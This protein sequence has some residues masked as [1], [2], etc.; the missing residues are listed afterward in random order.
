MKRTT[1]KDYIIDT[2]NLGRLYIYNTASPYSEESDRILI[3]ATTT[4]EAKRIIDARIT[5][6]QDVRGM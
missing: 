2:D 5:T 1:Y 3:Q 6:G 4:N